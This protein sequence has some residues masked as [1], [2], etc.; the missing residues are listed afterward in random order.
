[1][2]NQGLNNSNNDSI[3]FETNNNNNNIT[4]S[5]VLDS[6]LKL[7][8][9][10]EANDMNKINMDFC[11]IHIPDQRL[12]NINS[13]IYSHVDSQQN[14][15]NCNTSNNNNNNSLL[16]QDS[17]NLVLNTTNFIING[18][19]NVNNLSPSI[20][21]MIQE[22]QVD[23]LSTSTTPRLSQASTTS[24]SSMIEPNIDECYEETNSID[25]IIPTK[26]LKISPLTSTSNDSYNNRF[27]FNQQQLNNTS[28]L[29][30]P[31]VNRL[32]N[33]SNNNNN[34]NN[35]SATSLDLEAKYATLLNYQPNLSISFPP[36]A[37][38]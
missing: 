19:T 8:N 36:A 29:T 37:S 33:N 21:H 4:D 22:E 38:P 13:N 9:G 20:L 25:D 32:A 6:N 10:D 34:N 27:C 14:N 30:S 16:S 26:Q 5:N 11:N 28:L 15:C 24:N 2:Y 7:M 23:I 12:K 31:F 1:M 17:S 35:N 3:I 18:K